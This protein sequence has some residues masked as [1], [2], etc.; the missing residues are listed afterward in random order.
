MRS[1]KITQLDD[2]TFTVRECEPE[3]EAEESEEGY[4]PAQPA[5]SL[6]EATAMAASMLGAEGEAPAESQPLMEG[7]QEFVA[8]FNKARGV[9]Q[10]F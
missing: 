8:G 9:D 1:I 6:E 4:G 3:I 10:G 2:G 7:E 5:A